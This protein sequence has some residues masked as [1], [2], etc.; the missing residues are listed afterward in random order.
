MDGECGAVGGIMGRGNRRTRRK[1]APVPLCPPQ[2]PHPWPILGFDVFTAVVT[3][4]AIF[5]DIA[6]CSSYMNRCFGGTYHL[7]LQVVTLRYSNSAC[8][9]MLTFDPEYGGDTFL[10]N[11]GSLVDY[12]AL[13]P[14]RWQHSDKCPFRL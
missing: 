2:I 10:R 8:L 9:A 3:N 6:P 1:P 14:R 5:W 7:Y 12:T 11:V 13:Y 4:V